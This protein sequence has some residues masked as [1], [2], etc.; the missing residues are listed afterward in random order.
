MAKNTT[1]KWAAARPLYESGAASPQMLAALTGYAQSTIE[2]RISAEGWTNGR[3]AEEGDALKARLHRQLVHWIGQ[4]E[5][6]A[7]DGEEGSAAPD[8]AK[9]ETI[10]ALVR[11]LEKIGDLT[12]LHK[13]QEK[14]NNNAETASVLERIHQRIVELADEHARQIAAQRTDGTASA[15][16]RK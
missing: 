8:K 7:K 10:G 14:N 5:Q 2:R 11:T 13:P 15:A 4:I 9:I 16:G 3:A 6:L 12:R 1:L